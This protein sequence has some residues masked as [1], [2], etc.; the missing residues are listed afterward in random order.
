[1][2]KVC[3]DPH[4][5]G[6][7]PLVLSKQMEKI[8]VRGILRKYYRLARGGRWY[9]GIATADCCGCNLR[10]VFC[11]SGFP[12]DH[13]DQVGRFYS[14]EEVF[15]ALDKCAKRHGY[16]QIRVSGNEPTIG[17][18]HL[19]KLLELVDQTDYLFILETNGILIGADKSYAKDLSKFRRVHVRVSIKGTSPSE[20]RML[21]GAKEEAFELQL[22]ALSNLLD[23]GVS[24]HPAVM[25]SFSE[26]ENVRRLLERLAEIDPVLV[27]DF[28]EEY[29]FLYPHV[30]KRLR[31]A[32]IKPK[33]AYRPGKI[34]EELI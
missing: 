9:G 34:P 4:T 10:C 31:K 28:E 30:V 26:K 24:C 33:I 13:P 29:V 22:K 6:F 11:W 2:G 16:K 32:G 5:V 1:M 25:L 7:D 23:Y 17:R 8:V 18:E 15:E 27:E 12:R 20:F 19:L 14:P 21:T 3:G